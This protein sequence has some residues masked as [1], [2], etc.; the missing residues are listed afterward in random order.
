L[1]LEERIRQALEKDNWM[2]SKKI[3]FKFKT[4]E[5]DK[6][7]SEEAFIARTLEECELRG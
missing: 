3:V 6:K 5:F 4:T 1:I 7:E 2:R